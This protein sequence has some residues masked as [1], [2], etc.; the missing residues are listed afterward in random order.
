VTSTYRRDHIRSVKSDEFERLGA[1]SRADISTMVA[2]F[3]ARW[4]AGDPASEGERT[5]LRRAAARFLIDSGK[6]SAAGEV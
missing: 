5:A 3:E 2:A 6:A 4:P 1:A